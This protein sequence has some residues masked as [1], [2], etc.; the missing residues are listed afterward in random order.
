MLSIKGKLY[1]D[2]DEGTEDE[3]K[4]KKETPSLLKISKKISRSPLT[5]RQIRRG[6]WGNKG[7]AVGKVFREIKEIRT[8]THEVREWIGKLR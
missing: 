7:D 8:E 6:W 4:G 1:T 3:R 5:K 2:S